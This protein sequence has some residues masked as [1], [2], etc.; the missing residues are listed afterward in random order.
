MSE[1]EIP[2]FEGVRP[3]LV[4]IA[5]S[6]GESG[7]PPHLPVAHPEEVV[8]L[9][10]WGEVSGVNHQ[11]RGPEADRVFV[12]EQKVKVDRVM[13][14]DPSLAARMW[15]EASEEWARSRPAPGTLDS[16]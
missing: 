5:L 12:R 8:C 11:Y 3:D 4:A 14:V 16:L 7:E 10:V 15:N 6:G 9:I 2:K 1:Y 13:P